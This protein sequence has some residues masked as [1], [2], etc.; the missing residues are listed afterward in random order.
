MTT[1]TNSE[2]VADTPILAKRGR[3]PWRRLRHEKRGFSGLQALDVAIQLAGGQA[4]LA[5]ACGLKQSA[6][7]SWITSGE[8]P[9]ELVIKV[10]EA[11]FYRVTPHQ[12]RPDLYPNESDAIPKI[13]QDLAYP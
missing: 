12:L 7:S 5:E 8:V 11:V 13:L 6:V 10:C 9:P 1:Q 2:Q 3:K 4:K